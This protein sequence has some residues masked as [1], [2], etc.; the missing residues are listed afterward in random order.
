MPSLTDV[1][2]WVGAL[3]GTAGLAWD[4]FKWHKSGPRLVVTTNLQLIQLVP[5]PGT[6]VVQRIAVCVHNRGSAPTTLTALSFEYWPSTR[7]RLLRRAPETFY[8]PLPWTDPPAPLEP[9]GEWTTFVVPNAIVERAR[10][11]GI[12]MCLIEHSMSDQ[13]VRSRVLLGAA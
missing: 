5:L 8:A 6:P 12:L 4:I 2:A 13:P 3:T 1:V 11:S 10:T 9:G 7:S